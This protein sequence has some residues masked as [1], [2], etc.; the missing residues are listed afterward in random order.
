MSIPGASFVIGHCAVMRWLS[1]SD[2]DLLG[3]LV[4]KS[5][6]RKLDVEVSSSFVQGFGF[7]CSFLCTPGNRISAQNWVYVLGNVSEPV[8]FAM[9]LVQ[10][11]PT[12]G[13]LLPVWGA[14][15]F[16]SGLLTVFWG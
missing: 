16:S 2:E 14:A 12:R 13:G 4:E 7:A 11:Y 10:D 8:L 1:G 6:I 9:V 15:D 5:N 3:D